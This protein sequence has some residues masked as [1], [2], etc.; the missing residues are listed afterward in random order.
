MRSRGRKGRAV[1]LATTLAVL[2]APASAQEESLA[3][4]EFSFSNPGARSM[5]FGGAFVA[6]ADDAT[7]AF[8]NPAGLVQLLEPEVSIEGRSWGYSTPNV[9]GGRFLGPPS[10]QG[11]DTRPGLLVGES[12]A[13][14]SGLSF[15]S[16]VYPRRDWSVAFYRHQLA[17]YEFFGETGPIFAGPWPGSPGSRARSWDLRKAFDLEIVGYGVS[18][19]Y[20][21]SDRLS[22]GL[23][24]TYFDG[25]MAWS[26]EVFAAYATDSPT[27]SQFYDAESHFAA[28]MLVSSTWSL[29]DEPGWAGL[30]GALLQLSERWSLGAVVRQGAQLN[31]ISEVVAG[32]LNE[33]YAAGEL[34]QFGSGKIQFPTV[35]G[36]GAAFRSHDDRLT[37]AVEWDRV[38]YSDILE[39]T[40]VSPDFVLDDA[41]ELH[42]G[43]EYAFLGS[44]PVAALRLGAWLD[45]VHRVAY[46]G[47]DWAAQAALGTGSDEIHLAAGIGLAFE[48]FQID[49]GVDFSDLADVASL[50][51]IYSF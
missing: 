20:R 2:A 11:L 31:G 27:D 42:L 26:S 15:L 14:L 43:A 23:G 13:E 38:T 1:L 41:D 22:L 46:R 35:I 7:A 18:G 34:I 33:E 28:E 21:V 3:T 8:A 29:W 30:V 37:V 47:G 4:M 49:L 39:S 5:G 50:S 6:L 19:A 24:L 17:N 25:R 10:G 51:A 16:L 12:S 32:P 40:G 9:E 48:R 36:L 44:R 45:P